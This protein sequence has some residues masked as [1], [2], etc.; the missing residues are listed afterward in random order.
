[1]SFIS[2]VEESLND[3]NGDNKNYYNQT[4]NDLK[5][6]QKQILNKEF[7]DCCF[8]GCDFNE[9]HFINCEFNNCIFIACTLNNVEVNNSKFLDVEFTDCK[10]IGVNWTNAFWRGLVL[11]APLKFKRCMINSSSF[12]GL[13]L[14]KITIEDSRAHDVD[15]RECNLSD[16]NFSKTDLQDSLFNNTDLTGANFHG[17][18]SYDI[19]IKNNRLKNASF[20]R[21]EAVRLLSSLDIN[22]ID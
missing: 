12:Y 14:E 3:L 17:A 18:K 16:V 5:F 19:N 15:F 9:A 1:M 20:C 10:I 6:S 13:N 7:F 21:Y 4:F 8:K 2:N 22:L 11:L